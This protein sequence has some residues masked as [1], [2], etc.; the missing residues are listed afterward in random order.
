MLTDTG[1]PCQESLHAIVIYKLSIQEN[2]HSRLFAKTDSSNIKNR[3][4]LANSVG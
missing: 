3:L 2:I 1:L 4:E